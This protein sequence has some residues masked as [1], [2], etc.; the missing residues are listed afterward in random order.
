M[1]RYSFDVFL[2]ASRNKIDFPCFL[3]DSFYVG[4]F[5]RYKTNF[6]MKLLVKI[7]ITN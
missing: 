7:Y 3:G 5:S 1:L 2:K 6:L 4:T